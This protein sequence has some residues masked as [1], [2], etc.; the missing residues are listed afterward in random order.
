MR[1]SSLRPEVQHHACLLSIRKR[2]ARAIVFNPILIHL[3][4]D[5]LGEQAEFLLLRADQ[6]LEP[7]VAL[8][9]RVEDALLIRAVEEQESDVDEVRRISALAHPTHAVHAPLALLHASGVPFEVVVDDVS[10]LFLEIDAF[11]TNLAHEQQER[12]VPS[13]EVPAVCLFVAVGTLAFR[14]R[15]RRG[16][17]PFFVGLAASTIVL[18]G[19]FGFE[20]D[21]AMYA[22]LGLLVAASIWNT[23]PR[24]AAPACPACITT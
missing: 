9:D 1:G 10:A 21:P 11:F 6:D 14:A 23:W 22:R 24:R 8:H 2:T 3:S 18:A 4:F 19:K 15:R 7:L 13:V 16:F 12:V 17:G 5:L 20:S